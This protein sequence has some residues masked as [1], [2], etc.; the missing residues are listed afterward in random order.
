[1]DKQFVGI[2]QSWIAEKITGAI[3]VAPNNRH[4]NIDF[5]TDDKEFPEITD[6]MNSCFIRLRIFKNN[7]PS[8]VG[9]L[10]SKIN[11]KNPHDF[12]IVD[13]TIEAYSSD[14][15]D[16]LI[17]NASTEDIISEYVET[18]AG[19]HA[20]KEAILSKTLKIYSEARELQ[21]KNVA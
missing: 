9:K 10:I 2:K 17:N 14:N 15:V 4:V 5:S 21:Q 20:M 18:I 3:L 16:D 7:D 12:K 6:E 11:S 13:K 8:R 19:D 1:M